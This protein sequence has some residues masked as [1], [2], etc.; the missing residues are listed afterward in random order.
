M[1]RRRSVVLAVAWICAACATQPEPALTPCHLDG[2]AEEVLCGIERVPE[3]RATADSRTID[4]HLA[5][6]PALRR[7]KAPD[8][9]FV[10][11][12]GPGQGAR[13]Y[14][15]LVA[16]AFAEVRRTRDIVLVDLRGTGA[17]NA[18]RCPEDPD[19]L[20]PLLRPLDQAREAAR[21]LTQLPSDPRFYTHAHALADLDQV[22][23]RLGYTTVN[24]WGGSWGTRSAL[25]Y[26][27]TYPDAVRRVV[28][29]GAVPLSLRFPDEVV[30]VTERAWA[31]LVDG[32]LAD[33][34]CREVHGDIREGV[35]Q[36]LADL[37]RAPRSVALDH[38][39][40]GRRVEAT[41][42]HDTVAEAMRSALYSPAD[43]SRLFQVIR[44]AVQGDF[45]PL[46]AQALRVAA[47]ST[48][49]MA[50][51]QTMSIL[52]SEDVPAPGA[53]GAPI[54]AST[55]GRG[56]V[57]TWRDRCAA[58][59]RGARVDVASDAVSRAPALIL[60]GLHD[61]VTPPSAGAA[62]ARHFPVHQHLIVPGAA[63]NTS[64]RGCAPK[65]IAAFL[66]A[67]VPTQL[68]ATCLDRSRWPAL[69]L[70]D[71]GGL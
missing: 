3:D 21:C 47:A 71:A 51:G 42:T 16:R 66:A 39:I 54:P 17:S 53:A 29:D 37:Q 13:S 6:L 18:L 41:L 57:D 70:R 20:M 5:V 45:G 9:L 30:P 34:G 2:L 69:V 62:M 26:A 59:P 25:L 49:T 64:F 22:R 8:P 68:D 65:L 1:S 36:L 7:E 56:Y 28:L 15:P 43:A 52:C 50:G 10:M 19:P 14:A 48:D 40:T 58:W 24:L 38:P 63:H 44:H 12:G 67:D 23:T 61:P 46:M 32:C 60:S 31:L 11:A 4:I 55:L 27:L 35:T 33:A